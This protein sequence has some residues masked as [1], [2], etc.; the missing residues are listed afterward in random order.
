MKNQGLFV[1]A[2]RFAFNMLQ[3]LHHRLTD[4]E[5]DLIK[6][7]GLFDNTDPKQFNDM[8][9]SI[10]LVKY[11][12]ESLIFAEGDLPDVFYIVKEGSVRVFTYDPNGTK[13]PI[14]R[15]NKGYYFGE[16]AIIGLG[17]K[18]R[19]A[20]IETIEDA[21][22]IE[23]KA[24]SILP[25]WKE[26]KALKSKLEKIGY[27]QSVDLLTSII[28]LY[29]NIK[30]IFEKI[31]KPQIIDLNDDDILFRAGD[32]PDRVYFILNG[33]IELH[34]PEKDKLKTL[35][36]HK[37]H[38]LGELGIIENK[39]RAATA[40]ARGAVRLLAV[41]NHEFKELHSKH[42]E[43]EH[44]LTTLKQTYVL[45]MQGT[46]EQYVGETKELGHT[47]T[48]I[49][50][51]DKGQS[52]IFVRSLHQDIF[53]AIVSGIAATS[54]YQYNTKEKQHFIKLAVA[55]NKI[56]GI[57]SSGKW[58]NL[59]TACQMLLTQEIIDQAILEKFA[60]TGELIQQSIPHETSKIICT[61]MF[62]SQKRLQ[63]LIDSG[64]K[65]I[66]A[67]ASETGASRACGACEYKLSELL[68][69]N[70]WVSAIMKK[71]IEHNNHIS[72]YLIKP[73]NAS[74]KKWESGQFINVQAKV[75]D[76]WV[77]RSYTISNYMCNDKEPLRVSIKKE[78]KGLFTQWLFSQSPEQFEVNITHPQ[79][80][81]LLN[82]N[83]S[84]PAICFAG[85]I[86]ITPFI[87]FIE[88]LKASSNNKRLH[89]LYCAVNKSDFVFTDELDEA[90]KKMPSIS[91][92]YHEDNKDGFLKPDEIVNLVK[93]FQ[94]PDIY[95][96]GPAGF[97]NLLS[98]T[99]NEINYN[100]NKIH[101][102]EFSHAGAIN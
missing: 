83:T 86:G 73:I 23:I 62:V 84:A 65:T 77:E 51:M 32:L 55:E 34:I 41:E 75:G 100:K 38:L 79:G 49:F 21:I 98:K 29:D 27:Q 97:K 45:P 81:F 28:H 4:E 101:I 33:T 47:I 20:S 74:L 58:K 13:I 16:Q 68:G 59:E 90:V 12:K 37:G 102:E 44:L 91:I 19:N 7:T 1:S 80:G 82:T 63:D 9:K 3:N 25:L 18:T 85:G 88:T 69:A 10:K 78:P 95:I 40:I 35:L 93:S 26:D 50:K 52:I 64:V 2:S 76:H 94:D 92:T 36:I 89:L 31:E 87:A 48:N 70:P 11:P 43:L 72:S 53:S 6:K 54:H 22:L 14:A 66:D 96:C 46:V 61:C 67:L 8:L 99:L 56:V 57:E 5:I 39:P 60:S 42:P 30:P 24:E 15:L 17:S 71:A